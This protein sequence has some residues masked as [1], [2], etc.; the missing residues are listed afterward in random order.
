VAVTRLSVFIACSLD[1]Y[2]ATLDGSLSWLE[3]AARD[4]ED[5]GY[6]DFLA[7]TDALAMGRGTYDHIAHLDPLPFG[8]RPVFVFTH[9]APAPRDGL[10]FW[11]APPREA[12]ERWSAMGLD[13]VYVDGGV[14]V[15]SFLAEGLVDDITIT[16]APVVLGEGR[17]LFHSGFPR[18]E[19]RL[20]DVK[21]WSSGMAQ[22]S[23]V[24]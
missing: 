7:K 11:D 22:L 18:A 16:L 13:R 2:I 10:H 3:G 12:V 20:V 21:H 6:S 4:D 5:Y 19:L 9:R 14:L 15:S 23:Y 17:P 24:R 8:D 1:G